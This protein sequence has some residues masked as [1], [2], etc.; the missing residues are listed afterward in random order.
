[1]TTEEFI[2]VIVCVY[3]VGTLCVTGFCKCVLAFEILCLKGAAPWWERALQVGA[4]HAEPYKEVAI[5]LYWA[6][7]CE[8]AQSLLWYLVC[9]SWLCRL[10]AQLM[11]QRK[12]S[13][14][15][16]LHPNESR[17]KREC[18]RR[19]IKETNDTRIRCS[20]FY[21]WKFEIFKRFEI[22]FDFWIEKNMKKNMVN[23]Q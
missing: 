8:V 10:L 13:G 11:N 3:S 18:V 7:W 5:Q 4:T 22:W 6:C 9:L 2:E 15:D 1:M 12:S 23:S 19:E 14:K 21:T 20:N 17:S 16:S